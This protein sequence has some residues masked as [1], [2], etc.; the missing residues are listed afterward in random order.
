VALNRLAV[1]ALAVNGSTTRNIAAVLH[2]E[3]ARL[4]TDLAELRAGI[5]WLSARPMRSKEWNGKAGIWPP[6][7]ARE[8]HLAIVPALALAI[9]AREVA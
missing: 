5:R 9:V 3:I 7:V 2:I 6:T 4:R 1:T 8:A